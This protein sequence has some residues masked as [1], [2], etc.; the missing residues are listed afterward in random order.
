MDAAQIRALR[1]R[2]K[3]TQLD[4]ALRLGVTPNAVQKWE[5]GDHAP[6]RLAARELRR[7]IASAADADADANNQNTGA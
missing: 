5:K 6:S 4:F 1:A 2:L 3:L 7:L